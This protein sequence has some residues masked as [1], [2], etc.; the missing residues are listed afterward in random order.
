MLFPNDKKDF[1]FLCCELLWLVLYEY[2]NC[3]SEIPYYYKDTIDENGTQGFKLSLKLNNRFT[4][5]F[6]HYW[7]SKYIFVTS[8]YSTDG[9]I[10]VLEGSGDMQLLLIYYLSHLYHSRLQHR[11]DNK[12]HLYYESDGLVTVRFRKNRLD[13]ER[14][15]NLLQ[16]LQ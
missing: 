6:H 1:S 11:T 4:D 9:V 16:I 3:K 15:I 10:H 5:F 13:L 2:Y 12:Y 14:T 7:S 8:R